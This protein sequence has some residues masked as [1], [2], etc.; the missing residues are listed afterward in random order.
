MIFKILSVEG[1]GILAIK[2]LIGLLK[3][4]KEFDKEKK[5][6]FSYF[7]VFSG[8]SSGAIISSVICL[9]EKILQ[10][11]A[12]NDSK[13]FGIILRESGYS[14][15]K[16]IR[17]KILKNS[18]NCSTLIL[19][20][21]IYFF[22]EKGKEI[23]EVN[24]E[25]NGTKY[26]D[27]KR[28]IFKKYINYSLKDIVKNRYLICKAFNLKDLKIDYFTNLEKNSYTNNIAEIIDWSSNAPTYFPNN[29]VHIDGGNFINSVYYTERGLFRDGDMVIFSVGSRVS[30]IRLPFLDEEYNW[31][32]TAVNVLYNVGKQ[33][34]KMVNDKYYQLQFDF[35]D[36]QLDD[37]GKI[38]EIIKSANE[39]FVDDGIDFLRENIMQGCV[40]KKHVRCVSVKRCCRKT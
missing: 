19:N 2:F 27:K 31:I 34:D 30:K 8:V 32:K 26:T 28:E 17:D 11:I 14:D 10:N 39:V 3:I 24:K 20:F 33:I 36:Y 13:L 35:K 15:V 40:S 21:L 9:R 6:L 37:I 23:F 18:M 25:E 16:V 1:G 7:N 5:D 4:S 29:G 22:K 12:R 38:D